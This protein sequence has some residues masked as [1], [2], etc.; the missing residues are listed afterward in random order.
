MMQFLAADQSSSEELR[1]IASDDATFLFTVITGHESWIYGHDPV[2][3]QQPVE[4]SKVQTDKGERGEEQSHQR[5]LLYW[6]L[7]KS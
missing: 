2:T 5:H 3:K 6:S 7:R 4:K 1:Q